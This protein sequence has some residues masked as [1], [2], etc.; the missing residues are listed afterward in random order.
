MKWLGALL[1]MGLA[2]APLHG[3]ST[4][5][6]PEDLIRQLGSDDWRGR[7][8]AQQT[9]IDLG[10][11][12]VP[13]L[14]A[15][16]QQTDNDETR[17]RAA[18][19][20]LQI[21]QNNIVRPTLLTLH[22]HAVSP[23]EA[24]AE[25]SR[26]LQFDLQAEYDSLWQNRRWKPVT[27]DFDRTPFWTVMESFTEQTGLALVEQ[28]KTVAVSNG[29]WSDTPWRSH[30]GAF[31]FT[32][33]E[34]R[35][36]RSIT[37]TKNPGL[38]DEGR[39]Y[40]Q[41]QCEPRVKLSRIDGLPTVIEAIDDRG[42]SLI[43]SP[44]HS[45]SRPVEGKVFFLLDAPLQYPKKDLGTKLLRI[46]GYVTITAVTG[47]ADVVFSDLSGTQPVV[48]KTGEGELT[49]QSFKKT[50]DRFEANLVMVVPVDNDPNSTEVADKADRISEHVT[51]YDADNHAFG[52][53]TA[54]YGPQGNRAVISITFGPDAHGHLP[55]GPPDHLVYQ[56]MASTRQMRVPFEFKDIPLP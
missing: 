22:L 28:N 17:L 37:L 4:Q 13:A 21:D 36:D 48:R 25:M 32:A 44:I 52:R 7:E 1:L 23:Q 46:R 14:R 6:S 35:H 51:L 31:R 2:A 19:A 24:L 26:Q 45:S 5:P 38:S 27:L 10:D 53:P 8:S 49:L 42:N 29:G 40:I 33:H 15:T 30:F 16:T 55:P 50:G 41:L 43:H 34:V 3:Q 56:S 12:A 39:L 54:S 9:L 20:L 18:A 11:A 47:E